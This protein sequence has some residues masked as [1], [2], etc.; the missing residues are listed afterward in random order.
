MSGAALLA[1]IRSGQGGSAGG[2]SNATLPERVSRNL[3]ALGSVC[4]VGAVAVYRLY[5]LRNARYPG[6]ADPAFYYNVAQNLD[7]GRGPKVDF[8]W[9]FLTGQPDLPRYAFDYWLPMP[10]VLMW[11]AVHFSHGLAAALT[12]SVV[13]S[14]VLA[15]GTY[16][17]ARG[18]TRSQ[19]VPAA[20]AA[21]V[22]VQPVITRF[23][24]QA[25]SAN[26][27][28]AFGVLTMAAAVGAR[29]RPWLWPVAGVMAGLAGLSRNEG[30]LL[31][32][33]VVIGAAASPTNRH[34]ALPVAMT[35]AGYVVVTLPLY[36]MNAIYAGAPMLSAFTKV[37]FINTYEDLFSPHVDQSFRALLG[38]GPVTFAVLRA[39]AL[40]NEISAGF[41]SMFPP[42]AVLALL[43]LGSALSR[44]DRS[45]NSEAVSWRSRLHLVAF[46]WLRSAIAWPWLVP[47]GFAVVVVV[48]YALVVPV[49]SSAGGVDKA[50]ATIVPVVVVGAI[51]QLQKLR[52]RPAATASIVAVMALGPLLTLPASNAYIGANNQTGDGAA[53]L[54]SSL[55]TEQMCIGTNVVL[56]TRNPWE[57]TQATGFPTVM[58]PNAP[59]AGIL[60]VAHRYR[61]TDIQLSQTRVWA[62]AGAVKQAD[63]GYGPLAP[64]PTFPDHTVY[65]IRAQI[66][67]DTC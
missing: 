54:T 10:S 3:W 12:V 21:V 27:L 13:M 39:R 14:V 11:I 56:M 23:S 53:M 41:A 34:K 6:H 43:L 58:I 35:L 51:L 29:S 31:I 40:V 48:F 20:A 15:A 1:I 4:F 36:V 66:L 2:R 63:A 67:N 8:I 26:Y 30:L 44:T 25:E 33:V 49:V 18:L 24:V 16:W 37:P 19:W 65:R 28:A 9:E 64:A 61:V 52:F 45:T 32:I 17:L 57:I 62:L 59:L 42:D 60:E 38:G 46:Q 55:R 7:A 5:A 50:M 47:A 22:T